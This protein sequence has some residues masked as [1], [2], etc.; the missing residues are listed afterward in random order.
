MLRRRAFTLIELLVVIAILGLLMA[1]LLPAIQRVREASNRMRCANN[2]KQIG[3]ALHSFQGDF[4]RLPPGGIVDLGPTGNSL[5]GW[6]SSWI[7]F[8]LPYTDMQSLFE[9]FL[10]QGGSG[11]STANNYQQANRVSMPLYRCPSTPWSEWT[12]TAPV[13]GVSLQR[14]NYVGIA[15]APSNLIPNYN[16]TRWANGCANAG[17]C[18]GGIAA[19]NGTLFPGGATKIEEITDGPSY[20]IW[21]SE[22]SDYLIT[23][24]GARVE[25]GGGWH[26]WLIGSSLATPVSSS[27]NGGDVRHMNM[28]TIR[29]PINLKTGWPNAPG[30]CGNVGVCD[31]Y[32]NNVPLNS[33]H[34]Q[35]VNALFGG[36]HVG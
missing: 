36:G 4:K 33:P 20:V 7:V 23:Q 24:N 34:L 31:N 25:W 27:N 6:G 29:H 3:I 12:T 18:C 22:H 5:G 19:S 8:L 1:L 28:T 21:V 30:H 35:G 11:W 32:G 14:T 17:C 2:L 26:T 13:G 10:F 16:D 9:K 15:G